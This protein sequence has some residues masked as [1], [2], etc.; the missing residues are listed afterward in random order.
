MTWV[1]LRNGTTSKC[2]VRGVSTLYPYAG[3][4]LI[5]SLRELHD[6]YVDAVNRAVDE[7][8]TTSSGSSSTSTATRP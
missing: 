1:D 3:T 2:V 5:D 7:S 6:V 8:A 4:T